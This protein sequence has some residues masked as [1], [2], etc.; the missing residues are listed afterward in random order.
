MRGG[1]TS[2]GSAVG[3]GG[4]DVKT[5]LLCRWDHWDQGTLTRPFA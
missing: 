3:C 2:G 5:G 4:G 1:G